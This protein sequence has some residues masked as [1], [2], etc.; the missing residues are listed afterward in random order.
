TQTSTTTGLRHA[1]QNALSAYQWL[2]IATHSGGDTKCPSHHARCGMRYW[3]YLDLYHRTTSGSGSG[4]KTI[5]GDYAS[6]DDGGG[7]VDYCEAPLDRDR[8]LTV[9]RSMEMAKLITIIEPSQGG[10]GDPSGGRK[11]KDWIAF[12]LHAQQREKESL[13]GE[14]E[15]EDRR[16]ISPSS[17]PAQNTN[18]NN[19][20]LSS[21]TSPTDEDS[22]APPSPSPPVAAGEEG[23]GG[24]ASS[25]LLLQP[26]TCLDIN[27]I[28]RLMNKWNDDDNNGEEDNSTTA[29]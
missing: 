12:P 6:D 26:K 23:G 18:N 11:Y 17:S 8:L 29:H 19:K 7:M 9:L 27:A 22:P 15:G 25:K 14:E 20:I 16:S 21:S 4:I 28:E 1:I 2:Q 13:P 3:D 10:R 5:A 24:D